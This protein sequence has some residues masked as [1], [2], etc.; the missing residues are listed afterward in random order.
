MALKKKVTP[1]EI[2]RDMLMHWAE[3]EA[4]G[5][6]SAKSQRSLLGRIGESRRTDGG[7]PLPPCWIPADVQEIRRLLAYMRDNCRA[8]HRYNR[9][10]RKHYVVNEPLDE[11][12][13]PVRY[14]AERWLVE[15]WLSMRQ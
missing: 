5:L 4:N 9:L 1:L 3:W 2:I 8:G 6:Y 7:R 10:L 11:E 12:E 13:I 14:R 15:A